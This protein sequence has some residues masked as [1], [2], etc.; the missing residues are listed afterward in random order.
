MMTFGVALFHSPTPFSYGDGVGPYLIDRFHNDEKKRIILLASRLFCKM[1]DEADGTEV[2]KVEA[3]RVLFPKKLP[4]MKQS[5]VGDF[6]KYNR[7]GGVTG[8][9]GDI[10]FNV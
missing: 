10:L 9:L 7:E 1:V 8:V 4:S 3:A 6:L 2:E 5:T